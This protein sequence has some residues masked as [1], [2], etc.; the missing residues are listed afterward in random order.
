[1]SLEAAR[2]AAIS[3]GL[4]VAVLLGKGRSA[5]AVMRISPRFFVAGTSDVV[6]VFCWARAGKIQKVGKVAMSRAKRCW[7]NVEGVMGYFLYD[8]NNLRIL[9]GA[10]CRV[11]RHIVAVAG[12]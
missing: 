8:G 11:L 1:M 3:E 5:G 4:R 6:F 9:E 12:H 7:R 10:L 2:R